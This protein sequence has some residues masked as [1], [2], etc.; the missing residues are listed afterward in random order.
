MT[1]NGQLATIQLT[2]AEGSGA[3]SSTT[4]SISSIQVYDV[5]GREF[6]TSALQQT[7][8]QVSGRV[9]ITSLKSI[10]MPMVAR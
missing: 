2:R 7:V 3:S 10:F 1:G 4:L 9:T 5:Y 6:T 8:Q